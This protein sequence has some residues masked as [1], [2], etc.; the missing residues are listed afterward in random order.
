MKQL[1][2]NLPAIPS[3][4]RLREEYAEFNASLGYKESSPHLKNKNRKRE[5][6]YPNLNLKKKYCSPTL[7]DGC[8]GNQKRHAL[9]HRPARLTWE[10]RHA[11]RI[12]STTLLRF[13][14]YS[15]RNSRRNAVVP[16]SAGT[17]THIN[18]HRNTHTRT[19]THTPDLNYLR[20][21][22]LFNYSVKYNCIV[23][24]F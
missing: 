14:C 7:R 6:Q 11:A 22:F 23:C 9:S 4:D 3:L 10:R 16:A 17:H 20:F 13:C 5:K 24:L 15:E 18:T 12:P 2:R 19:Q 8:Q 1:W 21:K